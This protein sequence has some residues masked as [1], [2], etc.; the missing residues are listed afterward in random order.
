MGLERPSLRGWGGEAPGIPAG[1][2]LAPSCQRVGPGLAGLCWR[3]ARR[4]S[5][6]PGHPLLGL[7]GALRVPV[8]M[9]VHPPC[10]SGVGERGGHPA[11]PL[12]PGAGV[13]LAP[14][15]S[16]AL[17]FPTGTGDGV[18][19]SGSNPMSSP[20]EQRGEDG[21]ED[22]RWD[23]GSLSQDRVPQGSTLWGKGDGSPPR[24]IAQGGGG[25]TFPSSPPARS[26]APLGPGIL[27][28]WSK[29]KGK[30]CL[31]VSSPGSHASG[32]ARGAAPW[33]CSVPSPTQRAGE[34]E[35]GGGS[36]CLG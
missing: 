34:E 18:S 31:A 1:W 13:L 36:H 5:L 10:G 25:S 30:P 15:E 19:G 8:A 20:P 35:E 16:G 9:R 3:G 22:A 28:K 21:D 26:P 17:I 4:S 12:P 7:S 23:G 33:M 2:F 27:G 6:V 29:A 11:C 32:W 24:L 14:A